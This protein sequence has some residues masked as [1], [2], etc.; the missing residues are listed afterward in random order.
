MFLA[1]NYMWN[2]VNIEYDFDEV[3]FGNNFVKRH[4]FSVFRKLNV[5]FLSIYENVEEKG[6]IVLLINIFLLIKFSIKFLFILKKNTN[7]V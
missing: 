6:L 5:S 2:S 4:L 1:N 7:I 3:R